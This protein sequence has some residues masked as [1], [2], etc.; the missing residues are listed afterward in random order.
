MWSL[1]ALSSAA[2]LAGAP[3]YV[4]GPALPVTEGAVLGTYIDGDH[5]RT[6]RARPM[7]ASDGWRAVTIHEHE[8]GR[9]VP[10]AIGAAVIVTLVEGS[11]I[12]ALAARASLTKSRALH[13]LLRMFLV[14]DAS[15]DALALSARLRADPLVVEAMPDIALGM[16]GHSI[17]VPPDDPLY[18]GQWFYEKLDMESVWPHQSG[19]E[20]ITIAVID[21][22]C[23]MTHPDLSTKFDEGYD[24]LDDDNDPTPPEV[25]DFVNDHGTAC[26]GLVGAITNNGLG[27]AGMCPGCR[28]RCGRLVPDDGALV[29]ISSD[30]DAFLW[31]METGAAVISN[32]WGFN[33][34]IAVPGPLRN[35]IEAAFDYGRF[36]QGAVIA[37]AA[38]NEASTINGDELCGVRGVLC[39][40][41]ITTFDETTSFSNKGPPLDLVVYT[42]TYT[43][44]IAGPEGSDEGDYTTLFGGTSSS[45]PVAAGAA[46][47]LVAEAPDLTSAEITELLISTVRPAVYAEPDE[48]G[49]DEE[50]GFGILD[51]VAAHRSL[52]PDLVDG[53]A[54]DDDAGEPEPDVGDDDDPPSGCP[55]CTAVDARAPFALALTLLA[56]RRRRRT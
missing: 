30:V 13:P 52:R 49:H 18:G 45:C 40:G 32:S 33:A 48:T 53:G 28:I 41:A 10:A 11:A 43:T 31:A 35:A 46:A 9:D 17:P 34:A 50:Y 24:A 16:K 47:L 20:T 42:G 37:F 44:D 1:V 39:V 27:V 26:A 7:T 25:N 3:V 55:G 21:N 14:E 12:D 23:D 38:G 4:T 56:M 29:P 8:S 15:G 22:G 5:T 51:I 36:G 54:T 6:V 2:L 19:D